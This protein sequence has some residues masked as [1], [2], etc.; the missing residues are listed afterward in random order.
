MVMFQ[1][2]LHSTS[3]K[4]AQ[5]NERQAGNKCPLVRSTFCILPAFNALPAAPAPGTEVSAALAG[6]T[7]SLTR[8]DFAGSCICGIVRRAGQSPALISLPN[9]ATKKKMGEQG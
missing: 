4:A 1:T 6:E 7:A 8:V 5:V 3:K 9:D 2:F